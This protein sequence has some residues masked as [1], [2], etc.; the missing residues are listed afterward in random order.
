[1]DASRW[2]STLDI[3]GMSLG[4]RRTVA[5]L[6]RTRSA[7]LE[8][9]RELF[10]IGEDTVAAIHESSEDLIRANAASAELIGRE[11]R[12]I[13][14]SLVDGV[15]TIEAALNGVQSA[16]I[17]SST[18]LAF[19]INS[20]F[21]SIAWRY[22]KLIQFSSRQSFALEHPRETEAREKVSSGLYAFKNGWWKDAAKDLAEA[23]QVY[24]YDPV[25]W[26][27]RGKLAF[28]IDGD[29]ASAVLYF[30]EAIRFGG[31]VEDAKP[32]VVEALLER[33][34]LAFLTE[35]R[36]SAATLAESAVKLDEKNPDVL[37]LAARFHVFVDK[38]NAAVRYFAAAIDLA[39]E[40][41]LL[42]GSEWAAPIR[43]AMLDWVA[44]KH[45][46]EIEPLRSAHERLQLLRSDFESAGE[47]VLRG[48]IWTELENEYSKLLGGLLDLRL[49][50]RTV[51]DKYVK[52]I[53]DAAISL[54]RTIQSRH[55][56]FETKRINSFGKMATLKADIIKLKSAQPEAI[57]TYEKQQKYMEKYKST[58]SGDGAWL[59]KWGE[60]CEKKLNSIAED[61]RSCENQLVQA[62]RWVELEAKSEQEIFER[63]LTVLRRLLSQLRGI[64]R[65]L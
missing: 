44:K 50:G 26:L 60:D 15:Q 48:Q 17:S 18:R 42:I 3:E 52:A 58:G 40:L 61:L 41:L 16:V 38:N 59:K 64:G 12:E 10:R 22:D 35:D 6:Q 21:R 4:E 63:E 11:L 2:L 36:E 39:P 27:Y 62:E 19:A 24:R 33:A 34:R 13:R 30:S 5:E 57:A 8:G 14:G 53:E 28:W 54:E 46:H 37:L 43:R 20:G 65:D 29:K 32:I 9:Q 51:R 56:A 23:C 45:V 7:L 1:M 55:N 31:P 25:P 49:R 47:L